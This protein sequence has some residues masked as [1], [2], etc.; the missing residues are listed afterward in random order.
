MPFG[1]GM[2]PPPPQDEWDYM[3][4]LQQAR[5]ADV[6]PP[7]GVESPLMPPPEYPPDM[8]PSSQPDWAQQLLNASSSPPVDTHGL[9]SSPLLQGGKKKGSG[10]GWLDRLAPILAGAAAVFGYNKDSAFGDALMGVGQGFA[11]HLTD[12]A[13]RQRDI[14][15]RSD[16]ATVDLAHKYLSEMP[17]DVD[18]E[19]Y[20]GLAQ[21]GVNLRE[22]LVNGQLSSPKEAQ[23]FIL[24]YTKYKDEIDQL[25]KDRKHA[26]ELAHASAPYEAFQKT[27]EGAGFTPQQTGS[28][29][30]GHYGGQYEDPNKPGSYVPSAVLTGR[31]AAARAAASNAA[32]GQRSAAANAARAA[33]G[34]KNRAQRAQIE[35]DREA[36]RNKR[37]Q[38]RAKR[39]S[40]N[41]QKDY[42]A[43]YAKAASNARQKAKNSM[44][45]WVSPQQEQMWIQDYL[46][47]SGHTSRE[48]ITRVIKGKTYY[49]HGNNRWELSPP[50][51]GGASSPNQMTPPPQTP[52]GD[53]DEEEGEDFD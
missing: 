38:D 2:Q 5:S 13:K 47:N 40:G 16:N 51:A 39:P 52:F 31:E 23:D 45:G 36:G 48:P 4:P 34:E 14:K 49:Y 29:L 35:R 53:L 21:M 19:K 9:K 6:L 17:G 20:P 10:S 24:E 44:M 22:K 27:F 1:I 28:A 11:T 37:S 41:P 50:N 25:N 33:E 30:M 15:I 8:M 26:E 3:S 46:V 18:P 42:D 7:P 43:A 12:E 32:A